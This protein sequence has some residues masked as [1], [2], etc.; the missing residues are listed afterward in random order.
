MVNYDARLNYLIFFSCAVGPLS[1]LGS[2]L[3]LLSIRR[4]HSTHGVK[5]TTYHR[6]LMGIAT[7]DIFLSIAL[8]LG[9]LPVPKELGFPGGHG[10]VS[11]CS[12][13]AFLMQVGSGSFYYSAVIMVYYVLVVRYNMKE[14]YIAKW[15]EP[16]MH[17]L[18]LGFHF[19]TAIA[20]FPLDASTPSRKSN[21][22]V[23]K[24]TSVSLEYG[25]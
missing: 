19:G 6:L 9:P 16:W 17:F 8:T 10:N 22:S 21:A 25:L 15:F 5:L 18:G 23:E 7:L 11:T 1:I 14:D 20:G 12:F 13:Q 3:I 24:S 2:S 4:A